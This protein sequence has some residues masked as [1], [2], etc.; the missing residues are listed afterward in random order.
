MK[1]TLKIVSFFLV[2]MSCSTDIQEE[3]DVQNLTPVFVT[4]LNP[5]DVSGLS[6]DVSIN[7]IQGIVAFESGWFVTQRSGISI[8]LINYLD[9]NGVSLFHQRLPINSHGQDLSLEQTADNE[10]ILYTSKGTFGE[11]R[12]TGVYKLSVQL[13]EK[14][15]NERDGS[16][17][18]ISVENSFD[19]NYTNATPTLDEAKQNFAIRSNNTILIHSKASIETNDYTAT[20]HFELN[21][22]QL[23]DNLDFNMWFQGIAMKD[24]LVY[25]LAGNESL[26]SN[27][28]IYIYNQSGIALEKYSFDKSNF[29]QT[30]YD[31]F[32]PEGLTFKENELYF[33]IMT[34]SE[35]ETG[36]IKYLYKITI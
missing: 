29:N 20:E 23:L 2:L 10:L 31:K 8:L 3:V 26:L 7:V 35:L 1:L 33:T 28:N 15:N 30:F 34:K 18:N 9:E 14:I 22:G 32:E 5:T 12:N 21:N 6:S 4:E 24:N 17:T 27:K 16:L 36:N 11:T 19:L 13:P 25:C